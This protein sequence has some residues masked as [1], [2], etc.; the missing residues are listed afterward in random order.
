MEDELEIRALFFV[1]LIGVSPP[2]KFDFEAEERATFLV[3]PT[4]APFW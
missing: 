4:F 2:A 3:P 1:A